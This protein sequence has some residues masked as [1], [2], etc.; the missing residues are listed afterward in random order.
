MT[1]ANVFKFRNDVAF[2]CTDIALSGYESFSLGTPSITTVTT[3][4]TLARVLPID[5]TTD[6]AEVNFLH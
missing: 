5:V 4:K 2:S 6:T 3:Y 1:T